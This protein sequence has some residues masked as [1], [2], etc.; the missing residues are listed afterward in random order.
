VRCPLCPFEAPR[1]E[2]HAHLVD[3]HPDA[4]ETW[5]IGSGRRRYRIA[6]PICGAEHEARIKPRSKDPEFLETFAREIR[7]VAFDILLNHQ[8]AEHP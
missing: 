6:C 1:G 4:V 5:T 3:S 2:V 8:E 7:M